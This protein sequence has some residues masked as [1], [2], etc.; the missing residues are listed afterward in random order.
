MRNN[1]EWKFFKWRE[2]EEAIEHAKIGIAIHDTGFSFR[3]WKLTAHIFAPNT[4]RLKEAILD[5]GGKT[6]WIQYPG[7]PGQEHWDAFG[8]PL[9][10][11]LTFV[12]NKE[13]IEWIE[14][15]E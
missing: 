3:R 5:M 10:T 6:K 14:R 13:N 12:T 4:E 7:I 1:L 9:N 8:A 15:T 2:I 11:G